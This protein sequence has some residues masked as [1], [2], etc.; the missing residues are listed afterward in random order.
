MGVEVETLRA[1]TTHQMSAVQTVANQDGGHS[2]LIL[3]VLRKL[4]ERIGLLEDAQAKAAR[5]AATI[6]DA[7]GESF[8]SMGDWVTNKVI[9]ESL[10][11]VASVTP[12]FDGKYARIT[13]QNGQQMMWQ[14]HLS[15]EDAGLLCDMLGQFWKREK[16]DGDEGS[17]EAIR[18]AM[19]FLNHEIEVL[20]KHCP[21]CGPDQADRGAGRVLCEV[22]DKLEGLLGDKAT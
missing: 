8:E 17:K 20:F 22:R 16:P 19:A 13:F 11:R 5:E 3:S 15:A 1:A 12:I 10:S 21:K 6:P 9:P 4:D 18:E 14:A 2:R 7:A